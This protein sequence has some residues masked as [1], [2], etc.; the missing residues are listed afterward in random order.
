MSTAAKKKNP[1][2]ARMPKA[3]LVRERVA[4]FS[5]IRSALNLRRAESYKIHKLLAAGK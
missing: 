3:K 4:S 1:G 5:E 2:P